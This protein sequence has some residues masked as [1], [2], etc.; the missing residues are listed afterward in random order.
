MNIRTK[1]TAL[2]AVMSL[3]AAQGALL[4]E[5][6]GGFNSN[7]AT[8]P[9]GGVYTLGDHT[10]TGDFWND[11]DMGTYLY[12][13]VRVTGSFS[14][15]VRVVGQSESATGQ[16]GKAGIMARDSLAVDSSTAMA[17][18][19]TGEGS[20]GAVP[21]RL[22]GRSTNLTGGG[23]G[24]EDPIRDGGG[25]EVPNDIFNSDGSVDFTWL[26]LDYDAVA[27]SFSAGSAPDV[28]G[29]PGWVAAPETWSFSDQRVIPDSDPGDGWLVGLAYSAHGDLKL[30]S[31]A[32]NGDGEGVHYVT[33]DNFKINP[34]PEPSSTL[35]GLSALGFLVIRRK[36]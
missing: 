15:V 10:N 6:L 11:G 29:V 30:P 21:I 13:D 23:G 9:S 34:I 19:A 22:A 16:W 32:L 28:A 3:G 12:D 36:R 2:I 24:Y 35:L 7:S 1:L 31:R 5:Y 20:N 4:L 26:R 27:G 25:V 17:Q 18:V 14:A 33:F 8:N